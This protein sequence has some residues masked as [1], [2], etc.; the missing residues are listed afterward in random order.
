MQEAKERRRMVG[1]GRY[2]QRLFSAEIRYIVESEKS[3]P[4]LAAEFGMSVQHIAGV[5]RRYTR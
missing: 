1:G 4:A 5:R 3:V 2:R